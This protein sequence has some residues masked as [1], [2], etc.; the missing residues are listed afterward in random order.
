MGDQTVEFARI[1]P[2]ELRTHCEYVAYLLQR[3]RRLIELLDLQQGEG[4]SDAVTVDKVKDNLTSGRNV[5][6]PTAR[7]TST[8]KSASPAGRTVAGAR[9]RATPVTSRTSRPVTS[10]ATQRRTRPTAQSASPANSVR[11]T[12]ILECKSKLFK[13]HVSIC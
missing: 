3:R 2:S 12:L 10:S 6:S 7:V 13:S 1:I 4:G 8:P 11:E 5:T 9:T